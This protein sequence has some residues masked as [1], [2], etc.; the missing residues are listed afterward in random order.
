MQA[1]V[2]VAHL[3]VRAVDERGQCARLR[4]SND[5]PLQLGTALAQDERVDLVERG[6]LEQ[7]RQQAVARAV[8]KSAQPARGREAEQRDRQQREHQQRLAQHFAL[9][10]VAQHLLVEHRQVLEC[11]CAMHCVEQARPLVLGTLAL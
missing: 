8:A 11:R 10:A 9:E 3:A 7:P 1:A 5:Q 6:R 4:Q 2:V